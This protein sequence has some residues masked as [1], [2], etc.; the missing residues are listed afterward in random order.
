MIVSTLSLVIDLTADLIDG[1][2]Y[3]IINKD[4]ISNFFLNN[5]LSYILY[6]S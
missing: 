3:L 2:S 4:D 1:I 5:R 6:V